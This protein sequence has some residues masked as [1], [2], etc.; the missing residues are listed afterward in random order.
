MRTTVSIL[1]GI[2]ILVVGFFGLQAQATN[3]KDAAVANGT[4][5]SAEAYNMTSGIFEGI[6][7][8][9]S[10]GIVWFGIAAIVLVGLGFLVVAGNSGR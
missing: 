10:P 1:A 7:Q 3:V 4:N 8:A 6:G 5:A 2:S 9:A